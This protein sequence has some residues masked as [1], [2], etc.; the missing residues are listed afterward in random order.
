MLLPKLGRQTLNHVML[1]LGLCV[2]CLSACSSPYRLIPPSVTFSS[3]P[4][5]TPTL[6]STATLPVPTWTATTP[7]STPPTESAPVRARERLVFD[8]E[9]NGSTLDTE[10][11]N[12]RYWWGR[13][14][15]PEAQYYAPDAFELHEGVLRIQGERR[16]MQGLEY[17]S[18]L[19]ASDG[20]FQFK[21]GYFEMRGR[22]PAG[23]GL[24]PAFWL[25][26]ENR[27]SNAEIDI[28]ELLGDIPKRM[29][30][31]LH[32]RDSQGQ[33][34]EA[35]ATF[36]GPDFS[37]D[38]HIFAAEWNADAVTWY[39]DGIQ[40]FQVT[41]DVPQEPMYLIANLAIGGKWPGY[42]DDTT[43]LPAFFDI[44]YIRVY[45]R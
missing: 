36:E 42:P 2:V 17:T 39:V 7:R 24:W 41:H 10:K 6:S 15:S 3:A 25:L 31:T 45:Q 38:F 30:M 11:W 23:K 32:Y 40:R 26:A 18:G 27:R 44:D 43:R 21:Y 13:T 9:F 20:K 33:R 4:I 28:M 16:S 19:I 12:T 37:G 8:E 1:L 5:S 34:S 29:Y 22:L 14:N 35:G